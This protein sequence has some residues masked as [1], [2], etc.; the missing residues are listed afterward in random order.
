[1]TTGQRLSVPW[2]YP[3]V[4]VLTCVLAAP[5]SRAAEPQ[6][7]KLSSPNFEL[8]TTAGEKRARKAIVYFETIRRFF[9]NVLRS[10]QP[11]GPP[12]RIIA[13]RS[14][15]EFAPFR[16]NDFS[17][18]YYV[19]ARHR[20]YIVMRSIAAKNYP[21][22]IHEYVHLIAR[23][24]SGRLP[25]W[26]D[27][28]LAVLYAS[29]EPIA[30]KV[31]VGAIVPG[32][33]QALRRNKWLDLET[34]TGAGHDSPHYNEKDRAGV[35]YAESWA[36]VHMLYLSREYDLSKFAE[37]T[38]A[39]AARTPAPEAF[40]TVYGKT[41][42]E[43]FE[44][45][46][47][48]MRGGRFQAVLFDVKLDKATEDPRVE[49][50]GRFESGLVLADLLSVSP[51]KQDQAR[52]R[53]EK[54][55]AEYPD[56]WQ[57][58]EGLAELALRSAGTGAARKHLARAIEHGSPNAQVYLDYAMLLGLDGEDDTNIIPFL[59]KALALKPDFQDAHF[60]LG[61]I[62]FNQQDYVRALRHLSPLDRPPLGPIDPKRA[63]QVFGTIAFA[64]QKLGQHDEALKA[65]RRS[66]RHAR[67]PLEI[68]SAEYL[69]RVI[70]SET[71]AGDDALAALPT[72]GVGE[73]SGEGA[74]PYISRKSN[75]PLENPG[76]E[77]ARFNETPSSAHSA[78][79]SIEGTLVHFECLGET[80][81]LRLEVEGKPHIF[82]IL[83][84]AGIEIRG[85]DDDAFQFTCG[86]QRPQAVVLGYEKPSAPQ[87][88]YEGI[89]HWIEFR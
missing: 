42:G 67:E 1:M 66:L 78:T 47:R 72:A 48:Y 20:D 53:Y 54:L 77:N 51:D 68:E 83:D 38:T 29:L 15:K 37:F 35:F 18:A 11:T 57:A 25:P 32:H 16:L 22:A 33:Y 89:I 79:L 52:E 30:N 85:V 27:E 41:L 9:L 82:A 43:V 44:D 61:L 86:D 55:A 46:R 19:G 60:R 71:P 8:Y 76:D 5:A 56:R 63:S 84:P 4:F 17:P 65:A 2:V 7:L 88:K 24:S 28:G 21:T 14:E 39:I 74:M 12:I 49:K 59:D 50:A 40:A 23:H 13:F 87:R 80:V 34:L 73:A 10:K 36:L 6:W 70:E 62:H 58:H 81:R 45:L 64:H 3:A 69:L 31:R 26:L 75:V